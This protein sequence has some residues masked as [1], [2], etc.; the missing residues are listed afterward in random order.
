MMLPVVNVLAQ[1]PRDRCHPRTCR[2]PLVTGRLVVTSPE[3]MF[4]NMVEIVQ[5]ASGD[6]NFRCN[7]FVVG[8]VVEI[9]G[10]IAGAVKLSNPNFYG[11]LK[12]HRLC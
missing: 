5:T 10:E 1:T 6:Q 12:A 9:G 4:T 7:D 3:H 8:I 11:S 2:P